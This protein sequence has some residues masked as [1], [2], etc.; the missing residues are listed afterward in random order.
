[1][2]RIPVLAVFLLLLTSAACATLGGSG[3]GTPPPAPAATASPTP[4]PVQPNVTA[5][6]PSPAPAPTPV[7]PTVR[8]LPS[9]LKA[10][11]DIAF[12]DVSVVAAERQALDSGDFTSAAMTTQ[13]YFDVYNLYFD[14]GRFEVGSAD[15]E[16]DALTRQHLADVREAVMIVYGFAPIYVF[17]ASDPSGDPMRN[18][19]LSEQRAQ[20]ILADLRSVAGDCDFRVFGLG[21]IAA[22]DDWEWD[23][24]DTRPADVD[25]FRR[26]DVWVSRANR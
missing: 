20:A 3:G 1:M 19:E 5:R 8:A 22:E 24:E 26:V 12:A 14:T 11:I 4:G 16:R 18:I 25:R 23:A 17:G 2:R 21:P 9:I 10:E 13:K 7:A 6:D 15:P